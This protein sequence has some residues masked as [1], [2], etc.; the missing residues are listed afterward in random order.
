GGL[1]GADQHRGAVGGDVEGDAGFAEH[2]ADLVHVGALEADIERLVGGLVEIDRADGDHRDDER[3]DAAHDGKLLRAQPTQIVDDPLDLL[4]HPPAPT[5]RPILAEWSLAFEACAKMKRA[6][7][8]GS[9]GI[10]GQNV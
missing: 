4:W 7:R 9:S 3:G 8:G 5:S 6:A 10:P 2:E 1:S